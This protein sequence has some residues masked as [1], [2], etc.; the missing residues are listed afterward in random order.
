MVDIHNWNIY[1]MYFQKERNIT[2]MQLVTKL[3]SLTTYNFRE[4]R[5]FESDYIIMKQGSLCLL[6]RQ[7]VIVLQ[8]RVG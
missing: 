4:I 3:H 5:P 7:Q 6:S 1:N 8:S 2:I